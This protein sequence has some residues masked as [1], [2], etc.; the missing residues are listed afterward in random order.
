MNR[1]S[2]AI[3]GDVVSVI[4]ASGDRIRKVRF[5]DEFAPETASS[6]LPG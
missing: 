6:A 1:T 5:E 4:D 2:S 3:V